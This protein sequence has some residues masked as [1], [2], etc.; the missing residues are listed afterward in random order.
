LPTAELDH[1]LLGSDG[2]LDL[3]RAAETPIPNGEGVVGP[4]SQF[5][6]EGRFFK[7]ADN[8]RRRLRIINGGVDAGPKDGLLTDDTTLVVGRRIIT[9]GTVP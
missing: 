1:F 9:D 8:V 4:L 6:T 3:R 2:L 7:N 5:W